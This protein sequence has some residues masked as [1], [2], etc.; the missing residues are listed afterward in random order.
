[1]M[2]RR[3]LELGPSLL[4]GAGILASTCAASLAESSGWL[5]LAGPLLLAAV[6]VAAAV[7]DARANGRSPDVFAA[8]LSM[9]ISFVLA[10]SILALHG[11]RQVVEFVPI[12]GAAG[13]TSLLSGRGN[14]RVSCT[15]A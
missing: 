3:A 6:V 7:L 10:G 2:R 1:M 5:V 11:G 9:G 14:R 13:W 15:G 4:V 12:M 8:A